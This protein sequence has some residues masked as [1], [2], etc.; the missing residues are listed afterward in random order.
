MSPFCWAVAGWLLVP[1]WAQ[2]H[3]SVAGNYHVNER[4]TIEGT[5]T[6][7][8]FQNPHVFVHML[9][10]DSAG[11]T[12]TWVFEWDDATDLAE[13]EGYTADTIRP[14]DTLIISGNPARDGSN[15]VFIRT[16]RRPADGLEYLGRA[17]RRR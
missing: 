10:T 14:G 4:V 5:V 3:H 2:A 15:L 8:I 6:E 7:F 11:G 1:L 12:E 16:L 17:G 9:V 13:D